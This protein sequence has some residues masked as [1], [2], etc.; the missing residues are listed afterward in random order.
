MEPNVQGH[1]AMRKRLSLVVAAYLALGIAQFIFL[2][3]T[4]GDDGE[5]FMS[6]ILVVPLP[7]A[8][9]LCFRRSAVRGREVVYLTL[10][11]IFVLGASGYLVQWSYR[12]GADL[13]HAQH[14]RFAELTGLVR[15]DPAFSHI[16][17][18]PGGKYGRRGLRHRG[19]A[20]RPRPA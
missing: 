11:T 15:N 7:I 6:L 14:V 5:I 3:R 18:F 8:M 16:E 19:I 2:S 9:R 1:F 13:A 12:N 4:F 20:S 17:C 10:L